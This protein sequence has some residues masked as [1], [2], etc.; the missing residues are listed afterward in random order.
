MVKMEVDSEKNLETRGLHEKTGSLLQ[1]LRRT[2]KRIK[3]KN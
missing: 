3:K 1:S 2:A